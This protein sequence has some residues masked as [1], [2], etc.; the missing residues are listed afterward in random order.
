MPTCYSNWEFWLWCWRLLSQL[1][2]SPS[3]IGR[4]TPCIYLT[5]VHFVIP[6]TLYYNYLLDLAM[7]AIRKAGTAHICRALSFLYF[8][9]NELPM[10]FYLPC[11]C[12]FLLINGFWSRL[13]ISSAHRVYFY[14]AHSFSAFSCPLC[15]CLIVLLSSFLWTASVVHMLVFS[16]RL[17]SIICPIPNF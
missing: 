4:P 13:L 14:S 17:Q 1:F 6:L 9:I 12:R 16:H 3:R 5:N 8:S 11:F 7:D 10:S 15:V 2:W